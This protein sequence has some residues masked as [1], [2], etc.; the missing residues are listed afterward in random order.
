MEDL[1][2]LDYVGW[3]M[4]GGGEGEEGGSFGIA[5]KCRPVSNTNTVCLGLLSVRNFRCFPT[6]NPKHGSAFTNQARLV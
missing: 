2:E 6:L 1:S 4:S 3:G 5:G